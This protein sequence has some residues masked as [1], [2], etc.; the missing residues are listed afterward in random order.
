MV[1]AARAGLLSVVKKMQAWRKVKREECFQS[2]G[3]A[4]INLR[5]VDINKGVELHPKHR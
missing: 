3:R 1:E 4:P 2:T 5:W